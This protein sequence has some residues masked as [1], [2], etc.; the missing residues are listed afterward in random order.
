MTTDRT[1]PATAAEVLSRLEVLAAELGPLEDRR[2]FLYAERTRLFHEGQGFPTKAER[3]TQ[4]AMA[5]AAGVSGTSVI[6]ALKREPEPA[7]EEFVPPRRPRKRPA[8]AAA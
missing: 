6:N 7:P 2:D 5:E 4:A 3:A 1:P 8:P